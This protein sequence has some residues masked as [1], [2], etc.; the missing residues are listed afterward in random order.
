MEPAGKATLTKILTYHVV[1]GAIDSAALGQMIA[2]GGGRAT[3]TTV[4]GSPLVASMAGNRIVLTDE[5]GG[6]STVTIADVH[7]SNGVIFVVDTVLMP[8]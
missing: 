5:K 3:L 4:E 7:Q 6:R 1:P 8:N 2:A